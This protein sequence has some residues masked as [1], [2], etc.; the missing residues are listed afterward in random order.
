MRCIWHDVLNANLRHQVIGYYYTKSMEQSLFRESDSRW[1]PLFLWSLRIH[2]YIH[3]T[4]HL[5]RLNLV[6]TVTSCLFKVLFNIILQSREYSEWS[7]SCRFSN[8][9]RVCIYHQFNLSYMSRAEWYFLQCSI[10]P[11]GCFKIA[12]L[13]IIL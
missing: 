9:N 3:W 12:V 2:Y 10:Y 7:L 13:L 6:N 4:P 11:T 8:E 1:T 5:R